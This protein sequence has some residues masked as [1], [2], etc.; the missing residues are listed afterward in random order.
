MSSNDKILAAEQLYMSSGKC[1]CA[2]SSKIADLPLLWCTDED[3]ERLAGNLRAQLDTDS[4]GSPVP[5]ADGVIALSGTNPAMDCRVEQFHNAEEPFW[6]LHFTPSDPARRATRSEVRSTARALV[7]TINENVALIRQASTD[8]PAAPERQF[9]NYL[10]TQASCFALRSCG[11]RLEELLWY[12]QHSAGEDSR[13]DAVSVT[14]IL[15]E[16]AEDLKDSLKKVLTVET[17]VAEELYACV[18]P[19]RLRFAVCSAVILLSQGDPVFGKLQIRAVRAEDTVRIELDL[20]KAPLSGETARMLHPLMPDST[21]ISEQVLIQRFCE[22]FG[23]QYRQMNTAEGCCGILTLPAASAPTVLHSSRIP[24]PTGNYSY[25]NTVLSRILTPA[26]F[27][28]Q[29]S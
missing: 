25:C 9:D 29:T 21:L 19:A 8:R 26:A 17:S 11:T 18:M 24:Y 14:E 22:A 15:S 4:D 12:E 6:L 23:A 20:A 2:V 1:V 13:P 16:C 27:W 5:P 3:A 10:C 7:N 28:E